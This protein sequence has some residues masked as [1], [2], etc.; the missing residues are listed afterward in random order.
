MIVTEGEKNER[1]KDYKDAPRET[2]LDAGAISHKVVYL[3]RKNQH[4]RNGKNRAECSGLRED[5]EC[6]RI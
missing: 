6:F 5:T 3:A 1:R 2:R 4:L